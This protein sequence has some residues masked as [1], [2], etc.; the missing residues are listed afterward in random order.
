MITN[1]SVASG[2]K[3]AGKGKQSLKISHI[4]GVV[5][6]LPSSNTSSTGPS[7]L[8]DKS[9]TSA[10]FAQ[11]SS[12]SSDSKLLFFFLSIF[13]F[14]WSLLGLLAPTKED[15]DWLFSGNTLAPFGVVAV[16]GGIGFLNR[17]IGSGQGGDLEGLNNNCW[18]SVES[19]K[20][21]SFLAMIWTSITF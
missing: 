3:G 11:L 2:D 17:L 6:Q 18:L 9:L 14:F 20:N 5:L 1:S 16:D 13:L 21:V 10:I 15:S 19:Y 7:L 12:R 8:N 4:S